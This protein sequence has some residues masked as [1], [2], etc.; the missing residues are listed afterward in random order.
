MEIDIIAAVPDLLRSFLDHS[1]LGR[2]QKAGCVTVRLHNLHDYGLG[3]YRQIDDYPYGG[4]GGMVIRCEPVAAALDTILKDGKPDEILFF[5]PEGQPWHQKSANAFSLKKHLVL[6]CGHY[7]GIDQRVVETYATQVISL[8]PY[9]LTGGELAAAV[10]TDSIVRLLPGVLGDEMSALTDSF[11]DGLLA[12]PVY[13]RPEIWRGMRV[14]SELR[15]GDPKKVEAWRLQMAEL[16]TRQYLEHQAESSSWVF[17]PEPESGAH[18]G[19][20]RPQRGLSHPKIPD[21]SD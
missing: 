6:V 18:E 2:A 1:I 16:R 11:Q 4:G 7:K 3:R 9:V 10:M 15:S 21:P 19:L 14:P 5:G 8:G 20:Q 17:L 13:T 12:P